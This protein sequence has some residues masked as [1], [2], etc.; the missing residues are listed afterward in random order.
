MEPSSRKEHFLH[1]IQDHVI[2]ADGAMGTMLYQQGFPAKS[3]FDEMVLSHPDVVLGIH[4][5]YVKAGARL[6]E[7]NTFG[8]NPIRLADFA[9]QEKTEEINKA[10]VRL[11]RQAIGNNGWV[12]GSVGP[13]NRPLEPIGPLTLD[14]A[15]SAFGV[16]INALV[17]GGADIIILETFSNL[18]E[19]T[20][21][22]EEARRFPH[23]PIIAMMTFSEDAKTIMGDKPREVVKVLEDLGADVIGANCSVGPQGI[24]EVMEIM[25]EHTKLPLAAMPNAGF[26]HMEGGRY[27]YLTSSA[28]FADYAKRFAD[29]GVNI[30]GGCC[31]TTPAHISAVAQ[32]VAG[33]SPG[34]RGSR[35]AS[36]KGYITDVEEVSPPKPREKAA[37]SQFRDMLNQRFIVSVEIDPPKSTDPSRALEGARLLRQAGVHIINV[38]DSP[39]GRARMSPL[40]LAYL[41]NGKTGME[42]ILHLTCRDR[43]VLGLQSELLGAHALGVHHILAITGDP[44]SAGDYPFSKGVFEL[45]SVGLVRLIRQLNEG[46]DLS[47]KDLGEPTDFTIGVGANP[48]AVDKSAEIAKLRRKVDAGAQFA[49]T[50][51]LFQLDTLL[52]FMDSVQDTPIPIFVGILPL[53]N[54]KHAEFLHH[55]VPEMIVPQDIRDRMQ[56]AGDK[57]LEEGVAIAREFMEQASK[58]VQ[59]V[60]IMPPF[61]HFQMAADVIKDLVPSTFSVKQPVP[62]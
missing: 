4:R 1:E 52:E 42:T 25:A 62:L 5:S 10:A 56:K 19:I 2:V 51:P 32:A 3:C 60:Y 43:N 17:E 34:R 11:A 24:L 36:A 8:A 61:N 33:R 28:Y 49:F 35:A 38:A 46:K 40:A 57:G 41:I 21:A 58:W 53:R 31:G 45:D 15:R 13:L 16:Q 14:D 44:P 47:G 50:Q 30:I 23:V 9:L 27:I 22:L 18:R 20:C 12:A 48:N 37:P 29:L 26:P 55:E 59:G 6:L 54:A 39:L 7:T